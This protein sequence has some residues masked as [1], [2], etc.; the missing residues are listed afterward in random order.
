MTPIDVPKGEVVLLD[1]NIILYALR[2]ASEQCRGLLMRCADNEVTGVLTSHVLAEI[3][4]RLM[5]AEARENGWISGSNPA[6]Q[7]SERPN[8]VRGLSRYEQAVRSLLAIGLGFEPVL[9]EDFI[10][11]IQNQ[12]NTGLLMNDA[13]LLAVGE[14]LRIQSLVSADKRFADIRS[15]ILYQP[16]DIRD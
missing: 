14:R 7:L 10:S 4:H 8:S 2:G 16:N 11:A 9:R 13:L 1:A 6:K 12:R 3:T 5:L 15:V